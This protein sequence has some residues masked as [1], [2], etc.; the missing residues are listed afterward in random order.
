[1][2]FLVTI[3]GIVQGVGFRP[4]IYRRAI[5]SGYDGWV[6]N[7]PSGVLICLELESDAVT[8]A[9]ED[10]LVD[11]PSVARVDSFHVEEVKATAIKGFRIAESVGLGDMAAEMSSDLA[12]CKNCLAEMRDLSNRRFGYPYISCTNCGPRY[13]VITSLPYD[14]ANTTM[15]DWIMCDNCE[16]EYSDPNDR[17]FHAEPIACWSCGPVYHLYSSDDNHG[18]SRQ[19]RDSVIAVATAARNLAMGKIVAIKGIGGYHLACDA[20]NENAVNNLR[21][22]KFRRDKPFALMVAD[23]SAAKRICEISQAQ[24]DVLESASAPIVI[25]PATVNFAG[26]A[27]GLDELGLM[28]ASTP[29]QHLLF[30]AGA[31]RVLVMTS[32]NRSSE[33]ISY[34]DSDALERFVGIADMVLVGERPIARRLDDSVVSSTG[35]SRIIRR[36]RGMAPSFVCDIP[37]EATLFGCGADLKSSVTLGLRGRA[38]VSQYLG[39]LQYHEVRLSHSRSMADFFSMY[40]VDPKEVTF[41]ADNHPQYVSHEL[42]LRYAENFGAKEPQFFQHHRS[43]IASVLAEAGL[44]D[45]NVVGVALD[46]TGYGDDGSIWGGEFFVGSLRSGFS[47]EG[48]IGRARLIGG[49]SAATRPLQALAGYLEDDDSW[50]LIAREVFGVDS[51]TFRML[52]SLRRSA[53]IPELVTTSTGRLFDSVAA[54]CGF[55]ATMTY[56]GQAAIWL[57]ELA[58]SLNL[59]SKDESLLEP[60]HFN[61]SHANRIDFQTMLVTAIDDRLRGVD[62][63]M[64]ALRFHVGFAGA[65]ADLALRLA[66][67]RHLGTIVL[68]GGVFQNRIL[69]TRVVNAICGAGLVVAM[70]EKIS[71]ND[72]GISLGQ[73]ALASAAGVL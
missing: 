20:T 56:E 67:E 10:L 27:P 18:F 38:L 44:W 43:H 19:Q 39:D 72:E 71:C 24:I 59:G 55:T 17:R 49:D 11:L 54:I 23:V 34:V 25:L 12:V 5:A 64:I 7:S 31:P 52:S 14:R 32:G 8:V 29:L 9:I 36:S 21:T 65:I 61:S 1:M 42:A 26:V 51:V 30:D 62:S 58:S 50:S 48:S 68:S 40:G 41:C 66:R 13:S 22:A 4:H 57:E 3:C 69:T 28:V 16:R 63:A 46:G 33:P 47:R 45:E 53:R 2:T 35:R 60:Y 73:V 37:T 70:N 6:A 15:A